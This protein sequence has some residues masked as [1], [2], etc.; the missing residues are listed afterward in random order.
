MFLSLVFKINV[1]NNTVRGKNKTNIIK[2]P[3]NI[4]L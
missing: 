1:V 3:Y 2:L 4:K